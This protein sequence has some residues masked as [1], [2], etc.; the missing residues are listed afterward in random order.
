[1]HIGI[2]CILNF[3]FKNTAMR[4]KIYLIT[5][6]LSLFIFKGYNQQLQENFRQSMY[7]Y[8]FKLN[9]EKAQEIYYYKGLKD[10]LKYFENLIDS[11]HYTKTYDQSKLESGHYLFIKGNDINAHYWMYES[12]IFEVHTKGVNDVIH[13][14]VYDLQGKIIKDARLRTLSFQDTIGYSDDCGCYPIPVER[15]DIASKY[16]EVLIERGEDFTYR[17]VYYYFPYVKYKRKFLHFKHN[18]KVN[19]LP[20]AASNSGYA[21]NTTISPGYLVLNQP[22]FKL[23]DTV[24]TKAFL[25]KSNGKPYKKEITYNIF[26]H[27]KSIVYASIPLKPVSKGAYVYDFAIPDSFLLD[28]TYSIVLGGKKNRILKME[29]FR[30]ENYELKKAY[31][32]AKMERSSF[33]S[34]QPIEFQL[35]AYDAN[36][37]P[38]LD[39][40]VKIEVKLT[41]LGD[42]FEDS[43][44]I[45]FSW[46]QRFWTY[47]GLTDPS[48]ET[49]IILPDSILPEANMTFSANLTFTN[50]DG[51]RKEI[52]LNFAY[53]PVHERFQF[54]QKDDSIRAEFLFDSKIKAKKATI[55]A[56]HNK[57]LYEKEVQLPYAFKVEEFPVYY[58]LFVEDVLKIR[59]NLDDGQAAKIVC[60][61]YRNYDSIVI[62]LDNPLGL[63]VNYKIFHG[64][65]QI[66]GGSGQKLDFLKSYPSEES[67]HVMYS[68]RWKGQEYI[69]EK[70]YH[71]KKK[72]LQ[73]EIDQPKLIYPGQKVPVHITVKDY[74]NKSQKNVNI[75]AYAVNNQFENIPIPQMPYYGKHKAGI[76]ETFETKPNLVPINKNKMIQYFHVDVLNLYQSPFY[77]LVY[78]KDGYGKVYEDI[79]S[80][81]AEF[82]PYI[83]QHGNNQKIFAIYLNNKAVYFENTS[84]KLPFSFKAESGIYTIKVRTISRIFTFKNVELKKGKKLFLCFREEFMGRNKEVEYVTIRSPYL[85]EE[86][87]DM[88]QHQLF[89]HMSHTY[90]HAVQ[91]QKVF[92]LNSVINN[93][94]SSKWGGFYSLGP[95]RRGDITFINTYS[96]DTFTFYYDPSSAYLIWKDSVT[97]YPIEDLKIKFIK[98][99]EAK[100]MNTTMVLTERALELPKP[101]PV[102]IAKPQPPVVQQSPKRIH[103]SL[104]NYVKNFT[105]R[106]YSNFIYKVNAK[107]V[108]Q[109]IWLFNKFDPKLS[110]IYFSNMPNINYLYPAKYD[111][112]FIATDSTMCRLNG[113][114]IKGNGSNYLILEEDDFLPIDYALLQKKENEIIE[115]NMPP[116]RVFTTPPS[117]LSEFSRDVMKNVDQKTM[118]SGYIMDKN[119]NPFDQVVIFLEEDGV[120]K[121]GAVSNQ[122]GYFEI[123]NIESANY[124]FKIYNGGKFYNLY[125]VFANFQKNTLMKIYLP[126]GFGVD[127]QVSYR[128]FADNTQNSYTYA[129]SPQNDYYIDG[130]N[131]GNFEMQEVKIA[132]SRNVLRAPLRLTQSIGKRVSKIN[133]PKRDQSIN[134]RL[135]DSETIND[136]MKARMEALKNDENANRI[137][138]NFRDYAYF[139][140]NLITDKKGEAHFTVTFPDNQTSWKT[141]VPAID[142]KKNTGIAT[143][144]TKAYKPVSANLSLPKFYVE[145]D[146]LL[147][148]G[149]I[150]N[151]SGEKIELNSSFSLNE[152]KYKSFSLTIDKLHIDSFFLNIQKKGK[153]DITYAFETA[154][155]YID[156]EKRKLPVYFSGIEIVT[157]NHFTARNDTTITLD[158]DKTLNKRKVVM[159]NNRL[160][161]VLETVNELKNYNYGCNEQNASKLK[162]LLAEKSINIALGREFEDDRLIVKLI[163]TLEKNQRED[164]SWGW[165]STNN[166]TEIW[167]TVYIIEAL[168]MAS[169]EGYHTRAHYKGA[170]YLKANFQ[171]FDLSE[172]LYA[173][174]LLADFYP[175]MP[176]SNLIEKYDSFK[177]SLQDE[178]RLISIKQLH[179]VDYDIM[180]VL[181]A[182]QKTKK[183]IYWGENVLS[184]K[185]N[186]LQTSSLAYD[187]LKNDSIDHAK[188]L[189]QSRAYFL[190][191][192][193]KARNTV[194]KAT[195][196]KTIVDDLI[197]INSVDKELVATVFYRIDD[198]VF[199]PKSFPH[200]KD[201]ST[202]A[203]VGITKTGSPLYF[204]IYEYKDER[205]PQPVDSIYRINSWMSLNGSKIDELEKGITNQL[206]VHIIAKKKTDYVMIE[207]P[208]PSSCSYGDK[209]AGNFPNEIHRQY[210]D[211]KVVIFCRNL[212]KGK[213]STSINLI[214]RFT[215]RATLMPVQVSMMYFPGYTGRN[216]KIDVWVN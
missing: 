30:V 179:G 186:I 130:I 32:N 94:Y 166:P 169:K 112:I 171:R 19:Q 85:E 111:M 102:V 145:N 31:F 206:N 73:V 35:S 40:K 74:K 9:A 159:S 14:Y 200:T 55:R 109:K 46:H 163:K 67:F 216:E 86:E 213:Y 140:P 191:H 77:Q 108:I 43:L 59:L 212:P 208:I 88:L 37:L 195:L 104:T 101:A 161:F 134:Y 17:S 97:T 153:F 63:E 95:V 66:E 152:E 123:R 2:F 54:Y 82:S 211:N 70:S 28:Q 84:I 103:P 21:G 98:H 149:K 105:V 90:T 3:S 158:S 151:Y 193:D 4:I 182:I 53:N 45:P 42:F 78:A 93:A 192:R 155:N 16:Q 142:Y 131:S 5:L 144:S 80:D 183:G 154:D 24:K 122:L 199:N 96:K 196:I 58:D 87:K 136:E 124:Q 167:M 175:E 33:F 214:P 26:N 187:V 113:Y 117:I 25:L 126:D 71:I 156:G 160:D 65:E 15:Y 135:L 61:G 138:S 18:K 146:S 10:S 185:T 127:Y 51:D 49:S 12:P 36:E 181:N 6:V 143:L 27:S 52:P 79:E 29:T 114:E 110:R 83:Y 56:F 72:A 201:F 197:A 81:F 89:Y 121:A 23:L 129:A 11:F 202:D 173:L 76:M 204:S 132:S 120:F 178:F 92:A 188:L 41:R 118:I 168:Q 39:A 7:T 139:I 164:G 162:A 50:T 119:S 107:K 189:E 106:P 137:R 148:L 38:L 147:I 150:L 141:I 205:N 128:G 215:G 13:V 210:F 99:S 34:G 100:F 68:F 133:L 57:L 64:S 62:H 75:T 47:E 125:D 116:L 172:S 115:L 69:Y 91:G 180:P 170:A 177:L 190:T 194:E 8:V 48:G 157:G 165:W 176:Y 60:S 1:M 184:F 198:I 207:I 174:L 22:Q 44:F 20:V 209:T 203:T